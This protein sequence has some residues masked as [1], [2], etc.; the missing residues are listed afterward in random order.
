MAASPPVEHQ[1][2]L[3]EVF[4]KK[5]YLECTTNGDCTWSQEQRPCGSTDVSVTGG[6]YAN[7]ASVDQRYR[8]Y[9]AGALRVGSHQV[10][11]QC[12]TDA[13]LPAE[14][15]LCVCAAGQDQPRASTHDLP[16][17]YLYA[18][19][20]MRCLYAW[21]LAPPA[22]WPDVAD[23]ARGQ[24]SAQ[25]QWLGTSGLCRLVFRLVSGH[26]L[27]RR[28]RACT[29]GGTR[30]L[31]CRARHRRHRKVCASMTRRVDTGP[32]VDPTTEERSCHRWARPGYEVAPIQA[33]QQ[34]LAFIERSC[35]TSPHMV[36]G[37]PDR[38][39]DHRFAGN[40]AENGGRARPYSGFCQ[41]HAG[42]GCRPQLC[43]KEA[44]TAKCCPLAV[45]DSFAIGRPMCT[46]NACAAHSSL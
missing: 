18:G 23:S 4:E 17:D 40:F 22:A 20:R 30:V 13:R 28:V 45:R 21:R 35:Y 1:Q 44:F 16:G 24:A 5:H 7:G 15:W 19:R 27:Y 34:L 46:A 29:A 11:L 10:A 8:P 43:L 3:Y 31:K 26:G 6:T 2:R 14:F 41:P 33:V 37:S 9:R 39:F 12:R 42:S 38:R 25:K 32:V 36:L